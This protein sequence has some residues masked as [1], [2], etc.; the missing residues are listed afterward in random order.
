MSIEP[1]ALRQA[2]SRF[3]TGVTL[4]TCRDGSGQ[5]IGLTANSFNALSLDPPLVLW[6]L[7]TAS[8]NRAAF[9]SAPHFAVNVLAED[10]I[11]LSHRFASSQPERFALGD[12][13][14]GQGGTPLLANALAQF[15]CA[16]QSAQLCGDHV[17]F[18]GQVLNVQYRD[19]APLLF[20][21]GAY[22]ALGG[23]LALD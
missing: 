10:Q 8:P 18:I 22:R 23:E 21:A 1:K 4:I 6:S 2:L 14:D 3:A 9:E 12:W 15:E 16:L 7:R 13:Q 11:A 17:L 5:R 20:H 19:G